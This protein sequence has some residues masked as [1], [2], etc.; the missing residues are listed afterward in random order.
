MNGIIKKTAAVILAAAMILTSIPFM[1]IDLSGFIKASAFV[2]KNEKHKVFGDF[3]YTEET[4]YYSKTAG[5]KI[6]RYTGNSKNVVVPGEIDGKPVTCI[7]EDSF[8]Y[9]EPKYPDKYWNSPFADQIE[10]IEL[11]DTVEVIEDWA[12]KKCKNLMNINIPDSVRAIRGT[13]FEG[14]KSLKEITLPGTDIYYNMIFACCFSHSA[15]EKINLSEGMTK[16]PSYFLAYTNVTTLNIPSTVETIADYAFMN[17]KI[18]SLVIP[19]SVKIIGDNAFA[20]SKIEDLVFINNVDNCYYSTNN[21]VSGFGFVNKKSTDNPQLIKSLSFRYLPD[22]FTESA[23][24]ENY[25]ISYNESG[26][27]ACEYNEK[28][29]SGNNTE[30]KLWN[31]Y[32]YYVTEDN[33]AVITKYTGVDSD[34]AVPEQIGL[35][36]YPVVRIGQG[37]FEKTGIT[38]VTIPDSVKEIGNCAFEECKKLKKVVLPDNLTQMGTYVFRKCSALEEINWPSVMKYVPTGTFEFCYGLKDF[39]AFTGVE[40]ICPYAF[41]DCKNLII[42]DFG[43]NIREIGAAAFETEFVYNGVRTTVTDSDFSENLEYIGSYAFESC[44]FPDEIIIPENV[45]YIGDAAFKCAAIKKVTIKTPIKEISDYLFDQS[46]LSEIEF[47]DSVEKIGRCA[48]RLTL[49]ENFEISPS[50]T[51]IGYGAFEQTEIKKIV[52]PSTVKTIGGDAFSGCFSLKEIIIENGVKIM[53]NSAFRSCPATEF[54]IPESVTSLGAD[55][56]KNSAVETLYY[57]ALNVERVGGGAINCAAL[58]NVV[59]GDK[60]SV[61]PREL[62]QDCTGIEEIVLPDSVES[63]GFKAFSKCTSLKK[64][65]FPDGIAN[66]DEYAFQECT[67]L[68]E[69]TLPGNLKS[70]HR[71]ALSGCTSLKTVN[72][73]AAACEFISLNKTETDGIY[74]SP[75]IECTSLEKINIGENVKELPGFLFAGIKTITEIEL[76]PS[77]T[78]IGM[79]AFAFSSITSFKGTDNLESIEEYA[80]YGCDNLKNVDL[81]SSIMLIGEAA[82]MGSGVKEIYIP[83]S[84]T[85]IEM[86]AFKDCSSLESVRMSPNVDFIPREAFFNCTELS[87]FIWESE[88]K[89]IG[90]LAFGNCGK[91]VDFD[92]LNVEKLYVNS[93]LGSGVSVVQLGENAGDTL[94]PLTTIEV[95]SFKN[96]DNLQMLGVGG[97]VSSIKNQA[98]ADCPNLETAVIADSVTSIADDAFDGCDKLTIYC[99]E[100]SYAH[101]YAKAQGIN[102]STLVIAPIPNQIYTGFEIKPSI[103]V[104]A[105]GSKLSENIDFGVSYANNINVGNADVTVNGRGDFRMFSSKAKFTIVT[106]SISGVSVANIVDQ[107]YTGSAVTPKLIITDGLKVLSEKEDYTLTYSNNINEGTAK[108]K[109][110]GIGN[111]SG[112]TSAQFNIVK[113]NDTQ[114]FIGRFIYNAKV[115]FAKIIS[116]I[117][118]ILSSIF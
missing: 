14:C 69:I 21:R 25:E 63:I 41:Y 47:P 55:V 116:F 73:D 32:N 60:V 50:I 88:S 58:K 7:G 72:F 102:V 42:D 12:F 65:V 20:D 49:L 53:G 92:F 94:T 2:E 54:T 48:F 28:E 43:N 38:N 52:I 90:R 33:K 96:C 39:S 108:V 112:S 106:K 91:L 17:S 6:V 81:F 75:F 59:F 71:G 30:T 51:H 31:G 11:P 117:T 34:V 4:A 23:Y 66:I 22:G 104:S 80:F 26:I 19:P 78:D 76:P 93:F 109:I 103:S 85:N 83:N 8:A 40:I 79:G 57:N 10:S 9:Y 35:E 114:S 97:N 18:T 100:N 44:S 113:M 3:V 24:S 115:F 45:D 82:F 27:W 74:Y 68:E 13:P 61:I 64:I 67:A 98:F 77:V 56:L 5:I 105:S 84:V 89:L 1:G 46:D 36:K 110:T 101:S 37:A 29:A 87:S 118:N 86:E 111:Y 15:L 99:S 70:F 16:I 62:F 107:V 95:Q